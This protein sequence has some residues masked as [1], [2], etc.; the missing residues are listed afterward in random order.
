[1]FS[2]DLLNLSKVLLASKNLVLFSEATFNKLV[3][4]TF[5]IDMFP[6]IRVK[7][8]ANS[9]PIPSFMNFLMTAKIMF[10]SSAQSSMFMPKMKISMKDIKN[11]GLG[12]TLTSNLLKTKFKLS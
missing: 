6:I 12:P 3:S 9:A 2:P 10:S 8:N 11:H 1:M 4:P 5:H 7:F